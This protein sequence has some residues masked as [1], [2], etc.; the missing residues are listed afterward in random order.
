[1]HWIDRVAESLLRRGRKHVIA[2]GISISGHIHIGHASE[3]IVVD[4]I[5]RALEERGAEAEAFWYADDYDPLRRIPWPLN[6]GALA[7]RYKKYLGIPYSNIPSPDPNFKNF[8]D[9][10]T[11]PFT[12]LLEDLGVEVRVYS[13]AEDYRSGRMAEMIRVALE[14]AEKIRAIL[15]SFRDKPLSKDWLPF[16]PI[17][18]NCGRIATT[19]AVSWRGSRVKYRCEGTDYVS[20]CGHEGEADYTRGEGKLTW[21]VE[22]PARWKLLGVTCEPFG[23]DHAVVG[24]SYDTGK[25]ISKR[26]FDHDAPYPLPY[27]WFSLRGEP[28]SSSHGIIFTPSQWLEVAEPEL[29]RYFIFRSKPMKAKD[30]DPGL[31]LLDLYDEYDNAEQVYFKR[32]GIPPSK[33]EKL[34]RIYELSQL[35]EVPKRGPQRV[36]FRFAAV[37]SQ[38]TKGA[39]AEAVKILENRKILVNPSSMDEQFAARRIRLANRWVEQY[40]PPNLRFTLLEVMPEEVKKKLSAKQKEGLRR[41]ARDL[42][43]REFRAV[44]L[45][46]HIYEV[47]KGINLETARLFQ[48]IYLV[49]LGRDSGPR[50]GAFIL[51]LDR[52]FVVRRF[53]EAAS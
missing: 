12:E 26:I 6:Q 4:A 43:R 17:C 14:R 34:S 53:E 45:H 44:E 36:S 33:V 41:L 32:E 27:E 52:E 23:K 29:L 21:R 5:R 50:A 16:D 18:Q 37:L 13:G 9:F 20:G 47:A 15:N 2:S 19:R 7:K 10:F 22:W 40:A 42:S 24:G 49:L 28:M 35:K 8:V 46:N 3:V 38:V 11:R 1:M 30:F 39:E 51:A 48:A 25:L 31:P